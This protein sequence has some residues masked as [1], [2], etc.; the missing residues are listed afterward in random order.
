MTN[1]REHERQ[2]EA[3]EKESH[4]SELARRRASLIAEFQVYIQVT[5]GELSLASHEETEALRTPLLQMK[6][7]EEDIGAWERFRGLLQ[8]HLNSAQEL[9]AHIG[10]LLQQAT[11]HRL[12]DSHEIAAWHAFFRNPGI[13]FQEKKRGTEELARNLSVR[14][15]QHTD[16]HRP[17]EKQEPPS[18]PSIMKKDQDVEQDQNVEQKFQETRKQQ[19]TEKSTPQE[20]EESLSP[21]H[22]TQ[23][24]TRLLL[25]LLPS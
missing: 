3:K 17:K 14:K 8:K 24:H 2:E 20:S 9:H 12:L 6:L 1:K 19:E 5:F 10:H 13:G 21:L 16:E 7:T 22:G 11:D 4:P 18:E 25:A 23:L 15:I